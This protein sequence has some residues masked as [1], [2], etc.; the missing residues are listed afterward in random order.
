M[1]HRVHAVFVR[2][3]L[4]FLGVTLLELSRMAVDMVVRRDRHTSKFG[5]VVRW[6][7]KSWDRK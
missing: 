3:V 2:Y 6:F 5:H 1:N 7:D 4:L